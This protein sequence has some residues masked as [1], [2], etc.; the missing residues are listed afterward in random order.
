MTFDHFMTHYP[1]ATLSPPGVAIIYT[2]LVVDHV[3]LA[4]FVS[5]NQSV[6]YLSFMRYYPQ[7]S[8]KRDQTY[9]F[10]VKI[11]LPCTTSLNVSRSSIASL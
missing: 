10:E 5:Q 6:R 9:I 8:K 3:P 1:H 11:R 2:N 7:S 4:L